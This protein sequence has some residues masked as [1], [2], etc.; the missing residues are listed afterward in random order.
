MTF[1]PKYNYEN[2]TSSQTSRPHGL[3]GYAFLFIF[4]I[5]IFGIASVSAIG[6]YPAV[7]PSMVLYYHF[8]NDSNIGESYGTKNFPSVDP[9]MLVYYH[10]N[11]QSAY[12]ENDTNVYDFSSK[13]KNGTVLGAT[14]NNSGGYLGDGAF[15]FDGFNDY[16]NP[17]MADFNTSSNW[18]ISLWFKSNNDVSAT[19]FGKTTSNLNDANINVQRGTNRKLTIQIG[20][21]AGGYFLS[22]TSNLEYENMSW[23]YLTLSFNTTT[24]DLYKNGILDKSMPTTGSLFTNSNLS[25][26]RPGDWAVNYFNG[27]ID[28]F[29]VYNASLSTKEIGNLYSHYSYNH[30]N[31]YSLLSNNATGINVIFNSTNGYLNDGVFELNGIS[32]YINFISLPQIENNEFTTCLWFKADR[33]NDSYASLYKQSTS[34]L[35]A[36][37]I[38]TY[39]LY[40][41]IAS[42]FN[43]SNGIITFYSPNGIFD[44]KYHHICTIGKSGSSKFFIDGNLISSSNL[45]F[46]NLGGWVNNSG[47]LMI[48]KNPDGTDYFNGSID[49]VITYNRSLS[50]VE[51]TNL[52]FNY[53][54]EGCI[55]T[56]KHNSIYKSSII[57]SNE[58]YNSSYSNYVNILEDNVVLD[59][60]NSGLLN[61]YAK[62]I[63]NFTLKNCNFFKNGIGIN[64]ITKPNI[65][66]DTDIAGDID[67]LSDILLASKLAKNNHIN[68]LGIITHASCNN[69]A[70]ATQRIL[71]YIGISNVSVGAYTYSNT[72]C[73]TYVDNISTYNKSSFSS[74]LIVYRTLLN[75]SEDNSVTILGTGVSTSIKE[76]LDSPGDSINPLNGSE[77]IKLKVKELVWVAGILP[78]GREYDI[79]AS[80]TNGTN[81]QYIFTNFPSE[82]PIIFAGIEI[83]NNIRLGANTNNQFNSNNPFLIAANIWGNLNAGGDFSGRQ[84]WFLPAIDYLLTGTSTFM[85]LSDKGIMSVNNSTGYNNFTLNSSG[86]M[87]YLIAKDSSSY[88]NLENE[89]DNFYSDYYIYG[90]HINNVSSFNIIST[91]MG[92]SFEG[93]DLGFSTN[94][95]LDVSNSNFKIR[96][97]DINSQSLG[98]TN[99]N[100][101]LLYNGTSVCNGSSSNIASNDNNLNITLQPNEPCWVIPNYNLTEGITRLYSPISFSQTSLSEK[102]ITKT[103]TS[104]LT[105]SI[106]TTIIVADASLLYH[107]CNDVISVTLN[108]V[109]QDYTCNSPLT[110]IGTLLPGDNVLAINFAYAEQDMCSSFTSGIDSISGKI[111]MILSI[112]ALAVLIGAVAIILFLYN[113]NSFNPTFS[114]Q[115]AAPYIFGLGFLIFSTIIALVFTSAVCT[116]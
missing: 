60:N 27:S 45:V 62:N 13:N 43:T 66:L 46:D 96:N 48:G 100:N 14:W 5:A 95:I 81:A 110:L 30:I 68:L 26:G 88:L 35:N 90:L 64:P 76:L 28:D 78:Y 21:G 25:L 89:F 86:N 2:F 58:N 32:S 98:L 85:N 12:G 101:A 50:N 11:N 92:N 99:S 82:V 112:I 3:Q 103:I 74:N 115:D 83:G 29:I 59:C 70:G 15:I 33:Q 84:G 65:I 53:T 102:V 87:Y 42:N 44:N 9:R 38:Y 36:F 6:T 67:D 34:N 47:R 71:D 72:N 20:N 108:G 109:A 114:I 41:R 57:C 7:D 93:I 107:D 80:G 54:G 1:P 24:V 73:N 23:I 18:T 52:Y 75:N 49:E 51:I 31:D 63:N 55:N 77:L 97:S 105:D 10:F 16:I 4:L 94:G 113:G 40:D 22:D 17:K 56:T 91:S 111:G 61:I 37:A 69:S 106:N 116:L 104:N 8:N 39:N 79:Y 19:I